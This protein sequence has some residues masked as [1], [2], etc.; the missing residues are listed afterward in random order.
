M[1][2][3]VG[4]DKA[5]AAAG[6][7]YNSYRGGPAL[8][9]LAGPTLLLALASYISA[10]PPKVNYL[11]PA[12]GQRGQTTAVTASGE[13]SNWPVQIWSDRPGLTATCDNDKGKLR[14][15]VAADAIPG[16][17][18]LRM[19]DNEGASVLR[20]F[21]VGTLP[22]VLEE[23]TNDLPAKPQ[24]LESRVVVNGKLAKS[25]DVDGFRL[26]LKQGQTLVA[27]VQGHSILG[28]PMDCLLQVC[29]LVTQQ[30]SSITG[31]QP[32]V[33]AVVVAQNHDAIGLD[34]QLVF[35]APK[36]GPFLV[37][38]FAFPS[39]PDSGIRFSG[40]D[41]YL[42][43]L[44][45]TTSGFIDHAL[46]LAVGPE[47][48]SVRIGGWNLPAE[49]AV[50]SVPA[51]AQATDPLL[52]RVF[53]PDLAGAIELPRMEHACMLGDDAASVDQPHVVTLPVT[54]G[55]RLASAG[56][57]D[58]YA[59]QAMK[60]QK[61]RIDLEAQSL[62]FPTDATIAVLDDAGKALAEAD[63]NG[64]QERDPEI[65]FTAPEDG[66]YRAL[67]RDLAGRGGP[68][69]AYR[70]TI[71]PQT[72]D[73]SLSLAADSFMLEKDKP[74]EIQ[75]NVA[76]QGGLRE[77]IEIR[78]IGLPAG[79]TAEPVKFTPTADSGGSGG[80]RRRGRRGGGGDQNSGPGVKLILKGDPAL[81]QPGGI[82][83]RIEGRTAGDKPLVRTARFP[84]NLPL[85]GSHHAAWLTVK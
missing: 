68:R 64:R 40:G 10:A 17:Y 57:A 84:L 11:F 60:G 73:F 37:R 76:A 4:W 21:V 82:P 77:E 32:R 22:E 18:W 36:S 25:G 49:L 35:T 46:P 63:D 48:A 28:S 71:E 8:A 15:E 6:P 50:L 19:S 80:G 67:V 66:R 72:P 56:D 70:L 52:E 62:G 53:H 33:E 27:S 47:A 34:P 1:T 41:S 43:R 42:Y 38:I 55:W 7:S 26:E 81:I 54:I 69:I 51:A 13:F 23:E 85:A 14:I 58:A 39:E 31:A 78:A 79:V 9:S 20:P 5:A 75:V 12:G 24:A 2:W 3:C 30:S 29:E 44:T 83:I 16:V 65:D 45:I 61:I 59:F 74:L